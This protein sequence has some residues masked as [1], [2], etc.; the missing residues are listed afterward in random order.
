MSVRISKSGEH[1]QQGTVVYTA[2]TESDIES[3]PNT[4]T[5]GSTCFCIETS[6][7]YILNNQ[8]EWKVKSTSGGGGGGGGGG[9]SYPSADDRTFPISNDNITFTTQSRW[10]NEIVNGINEKSGTENSYNPSQ[11]KQAILD[12]P[13]GDEFKAM[14]EGGIRRSISSKSLTVNEKGFSYQMYTLDNENYFLAYATCPMVIY[15]QYKMT[16]EEGSTDFE[17][18]INGFWQ[19]NQDNNGVLVFHDSWEKGNMSILQNGIP[20]NEACGTTDFTW[21]NGSHY[22]DISASINNNH[23]LI[24]KPSKVINLDEEKSHPYAVKLYKD[25]EETVLIDYITDGFSADLE[26]FMV[27]DSTC[28]PNDFDLSLIDKC[29]LIYSTNNCFIL[30]AMTENNEGLYVDGNG[31]LNSPSGNLYC[32]TSWNTTTGTPSGAPLKL[33][34]VYKSGKPPFAE[35]SGDNYYT[36]VMLNT[37]DILDGQNNV[38]VPANITLAEFKEKIFKLNNES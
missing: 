38:K 19:K 3:L 25:E 15:L 9:T 29:Y 7:T 13:V 16:R 21:T 27:C 18:L 8:G 28:V 36:N 1:V 10:Y 31:K 33:P 22:I 11:M 4:C 17:F 2:D 30:I 20:K 35:G 12:I 6:T 37:V 24:Y 5:P 34:I 26:D 32:Q 14:V 23:P